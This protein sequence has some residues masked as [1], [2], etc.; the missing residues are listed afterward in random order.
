M[1]LLMDPAVFLNTTDLF[2]FILFKLSPQDA[3]T[4]S[5][6]TPNKDQEINET[7]IFR[8]YLVGYGLRFLFILTLSFHYCVLNFVLENSNT[9][10]RWLH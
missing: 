9:K 7:V 1:V 5:Y 2:C 10:M 4:S 3:Q 8:I 6:I